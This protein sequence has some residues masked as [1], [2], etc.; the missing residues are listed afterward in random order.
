M[1]DCSAATRVENKLI[2]LSKTKDREKKREIYYLQPLV[3]TFS[4]EFMIARQYSEKL[5]RFPVAHAYDAS[6]IDKQQ[7]KHTAHSSV[8]IDCKQKKATLGLEQ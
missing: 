5:L 6:A 7:F 2:Q 1:Y 4:M 8:S 3:N